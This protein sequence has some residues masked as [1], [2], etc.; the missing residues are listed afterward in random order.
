MTQVNEFFKETPSPVA[1]NA[2]TETDV[3]STISKANDHL[4]DTRHLEKM[5]LYITNPDGA[6]VSNAIIYIS[7]SETTPV[8]VEHIASTPV[9][10]SSTIYLEVDAVCAA[11]KIAGISASGTPN[12]TAKMIKRTR[13]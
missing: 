10:V 8:W 9:A 11:I 4:F 12:M 13:H 6:I 1:L 5:G 7:A 2:S 3:L